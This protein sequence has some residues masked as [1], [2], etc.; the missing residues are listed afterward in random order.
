MCV[1]S[2]LCVR[3]SEWVRSSQRPYHFYSLPIKK[4]ESASPSLGKFHTTPSWRIMTK[5][6]NNCWKR[7]T[8]GQSSSLPVKKTYGEQHSTFWLHPCCS[9]TLITCHVG[10]FN[11]W[12]AA[13]QDGARGTDFPC[14]QNVCYPNMPR[15]EVGLQ[16]KTKQQRYC[17]ILQCPTG[18]DYVKK[19]RMKHLAPVNSEWGIQKWMNT[20]DVKEKRRWVRDMEM[21]TVTHTVIFKCSTQHIIH[22]VAVNTK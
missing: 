16:I 14:V 1:C 5:P 8:R 4:V 13:P 21:M 2:H 10:V 9:G 3:V 20:W 17:L 7:S 15:K 22:T 18:N 19:H 6:S 11:L 12:V